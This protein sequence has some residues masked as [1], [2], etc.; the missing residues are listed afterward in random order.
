MTISRQEA[1]WVRLGVELA[2]A[3][4]KGMSSKA[5]AESKN[6]NYSTFTKSMSRYQ[7]KIKLAVRAD[8]LLQKPT[9]RLTQADKNL[10]MINSFRQSV[11][12]KI[13]NDGA[14]SNTK[15]QKW[16]DKTIK[17]AVRG[18]KVSKPASGKV[19]AFAYDAKYKDTLPYW[20]RFPL[21]VCLGFV[22]SPKS[23]T[24]LMQG[25]NMHYVPPKA[26][27]E[28]LESILKYSNTS[29]ISNKTMLKVDWSKVKNLP[30]ADKMIKNYLPSHIVGTI[31][32]IKPSDWSNVVL[33]PLQQFLSKGKRYSSQKVW[34]KK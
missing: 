24:I 29:V 7:T 30:G 2:R 21:I 1:D 17:D 6:I 27:Q 31:T 22:K 20:D 26:R 4:K 25:L 12:E 13:K 18:H 15:S 8:E 23:G 14:A 3:K 11:R 16:F 19:Y 34:G 10:I 5:F 32:E 9:N 33:M 28:F